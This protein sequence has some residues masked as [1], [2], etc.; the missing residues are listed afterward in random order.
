MTQAQEKMAL[1]A[2]AGALD[3]QLGPHASGATR[4]LKSF[5][6]TAPLDLTFSKP[7]EPIY[8][9]HAPLNIRAMLRNL[10]LL[11]L[12]AALFLA[13]SIFST[14]VYFPY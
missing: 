13:A 9:S 3:L 12:L 6:S 5:C 14:L 4:D 8:F 7:L 11:G 10:I 2:V 1:A